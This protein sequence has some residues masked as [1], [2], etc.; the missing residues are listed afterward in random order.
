MWPES[1]LVLMLRWSWTTTMKGERLSVSL[2]ALMVVTTTTEKWRR[3]FA[4]RDLV[5]VVCL[6]ES[7][8]EEGEHASSQ[9][10]INQAPVQRRP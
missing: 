8:R 3:A 10:Y 9:V 4:G 1:A 2:T 6:R 7:R 5:C